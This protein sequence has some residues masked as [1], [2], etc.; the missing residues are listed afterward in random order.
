[1]TNL[2]EYRG[3]WRG[4]AIAKYNYCVY[5]CV[6]VHAQLCPTFCDPVDY[7]SPVS[8]LHGIVQARI[9]GWIAIPFWDLPNP[10]IQPRNQ[11]QV[12][13]IALDSLPSQELNQGLLHCRQILYQLN[14][15][16]SRF[17]LLGSKHS[18]SFY[19]LF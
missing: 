11:T 10:G 14:Y 13:H 4:S 1:M 9:L 7:S 8:S 19:D 2:T 12:S 6:C 16:G 15:Q 17:F 18:H 5:M 3:K